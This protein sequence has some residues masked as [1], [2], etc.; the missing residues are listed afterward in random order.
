MEKERREYISRM[1]GLAK[2]EPPEFDGGLGLVT[3][4]LQYMSSTVPRVT[5]AEVEEVLRE[6]AAVS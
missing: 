3:R 1:I 2:D 5:Q 4:A 6:D